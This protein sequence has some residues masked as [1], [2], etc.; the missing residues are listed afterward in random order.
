MHTERRRQTTCP[1]GL[2]PGMFA[3]CVCWCVF[4]CFWLV[5]G[6]MVCSVRW[7]VCLLVSWLIPSFVSGVVPWLV[8]WFVGWV[9]IVLCHGAGTGFA[10]RSPLA[11]VV[12]VC[13]VSHAVARCLVG[14]RCWCPVL[15]VGL[16]SHVRENA[17]YFFI[18]SRCLHSH[19]CSSVY[20]AI[21]NFLSAHLI[22]LQS[23][24]CL[25]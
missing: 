18:E 22:K 6:L 10:A 11:A 23:V 2:R 25:T 19:E 5:V 4:V 3:V 9:C 14:V 17:W 8:S 20:S 1:S 15:G 24:A 7:C 12:C 16:Q 21:F 13:S